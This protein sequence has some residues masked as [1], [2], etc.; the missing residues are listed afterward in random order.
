MGRVRASLQRLSHNAGPITVVG[1]FLLLA[2]VVYQQ[3]RSNQ[4]GT[5]IANQQKIIV[6]LQ[7]AQAAS[8]TQ[9]RAL[10]RGVQQTNDLILG[11]TSP[12]STA[13]MEQQA[14]VAGYLASLAS[15]NQQAINDQTRRIGEM[16]TQCRV[17]PCATSTIA[18]ILGEPVPTPTFA[19]MAA[20]TTPGTVPRVSLLPASPAPV[21]KPVNSARST[22]GVTVCPGIQLPPILN[23]PQ[24]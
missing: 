14:K 24:G 23:C 17:L 15:A 3:F 20:V 6:G 7:Q 19:G 22:G 8:S 9:G 21:P 12:T 10:L 16:F 18:K 11:F 2:V 1:M 13:T 4:Q 5:T